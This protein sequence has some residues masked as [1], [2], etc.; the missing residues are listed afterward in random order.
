M[1]L[2]CLTSESAP[3]VTTRDAL[4]VSLGHFHPE[5]RNLVTVCPELPR[6]SDIYPIVSSLLA[7]IIAT[8]VLLFFGDF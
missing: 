6:S 8:H 7:M 4:S 2:G 5:T 1:N 3:L